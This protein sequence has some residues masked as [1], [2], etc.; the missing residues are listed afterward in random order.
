[1][2]GW[3]GLPGKVVQLPVELELKK[4]PETLILMPNMVVWNAKEMIMNTKIAAMRKPVPVRN[5]TE[6]SCNLNP[7]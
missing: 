4:E 7:F 1:M 5:M 2:N 6:F 3:N